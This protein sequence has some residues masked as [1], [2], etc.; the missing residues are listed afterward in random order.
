LRIGFF[1]FTGDK[2]FPFRLHGRRTLE[3]FE[4]L[5][6]HSRQIPGDVRICRVPDLSG[7]S[8]RQAW[9]T[10]RAELP[11]ASF[12]FDSSELQRSRGLHAKGA[13]RGAS[14]MPGRSSAVFCN[15]SWL[16]LRALARYSRQKTAQRLYQ[17]RSMTD[18]YLS[19]I[20]AAL[21]HRFLRDANLSPLFA[22]KV[23]FAS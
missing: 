22:L 16:V 9:A 5:T 7:L 20:S 19:L 18:Q 8:L 1:F 4:P 21:S 2:A 15:G 6:P 17:S 14:C 12:L 23:R 11:A 10:V 13:S 3:I